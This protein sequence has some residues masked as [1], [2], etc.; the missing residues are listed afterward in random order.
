MGGYRPDEV[1]SDRRNLLSQDKSNDL[2]RAA[3]RIGELGLAD[4][5]LLEARTILRLLSDS[6]PSATERWLV[7]QHPQ[8]GGATPLELISRHEFELVKDVIPSDT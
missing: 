4:D 5:E 7:S 8:L 2:E 6:V 3:R 1:V